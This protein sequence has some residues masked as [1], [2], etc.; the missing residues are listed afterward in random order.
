MV[1]IDNRPF[2]EFIL[3]NLSSKGIK[4]YLVLSGYLGDKIKDYFGSGEKWNIDIQYSHGPT[5]WDTAKRLWE[6]RDLL[7]EN[8]LFLYSDN[9]IN[10]NLRQLCRVAGPRRED[11]GSGFEARIS[12]R[13]GPKGPRDNQNSIDR[14]PLQ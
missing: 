9:Y 3:E 13:R 11:R 7:D 6:S 1:S 14:K 8:F 12:Q 4:K 5:E 10:L 2:L